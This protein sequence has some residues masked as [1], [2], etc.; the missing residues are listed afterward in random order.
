VGA[1]FGGPQTASL[2]KLCP[3]FAGIFSG[4]LAV[5]PLTAINAEP[6]YRFGGSGWAS[7]TFKGFRPSPILSGHERDVAAKAASALA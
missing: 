4:F 2:A 7:G 6:L 5:R 1:A 3:R